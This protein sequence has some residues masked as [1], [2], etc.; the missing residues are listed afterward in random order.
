MEIKP[1]E[2]HLQDTVPITF[3]D[4][5]NIVELLNILFDNMVEAKSLML[6]IKGLDFKVGTGI[7]HGLMT[8]TL[9]IPE[10]VVKKIINMTIATQ[11]VALFDS[12]APLVPDVANNPFTGNLVLHKRYENDKYELVLCCSTNLIGDFTL[13]FNYI[14]A[15]ITAINKAVFSN[16][17]TGSSFQDEFDKLLH[18]EDFGEG[19]PDKFDNDYSIYETIKPVKILPNAYC[20]GD[21]NSYT[22]VESNKFAYEFG[23]YGFKYVATN[24]GCEVYL[25]VRCKGA[26]PPMFGIRGKFYFMGR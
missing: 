8:Q 4:G 23:N 13:I 19:I 21:E 15:P 17:I 14:L 1:F 22:F 10:S 9:D 5:Y 20:Y 18:D 2:K 26:L 6:D 16:T 12:Y 25:L 24:N 7:Y 11:G 3:N